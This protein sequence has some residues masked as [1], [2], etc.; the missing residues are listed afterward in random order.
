MQIVYYLSLL[1][2]CHNI[3][4]GRIHI[5]SEETQ[6][7]KIYFPSFNIIVYGFLWLVSGSDYFTIGNYKTKYIDTNNW[8][9]F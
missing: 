6:L 9:C 4:L 2:L 7:N 1:L 5:I 8:R 3:V